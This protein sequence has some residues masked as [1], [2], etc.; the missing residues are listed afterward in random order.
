MPKIQKQSGTAFLMAIIAISLFGTNAVAL[1]VATDTMDPLVY[2]S[3]RYIGIGAILLLFL[4]NF[5]FLKK[6]GIIPKILIG[7]FLLM[8]YMVFFALG[9]S[10]SG[11]LKAA[12]MSL[13]TP[14]MVYI[15]SIILLHE[16]FIRRIVLGGL[17]AL[18]GSIILI[19]LPVVLG[20]SVSFG[21]IL[22]FLAYTA[23]AA[24]II[25]GKHMFRW[26]TTNELLSMRFAIGGI[27]LF[28]LVLFTSGP[29]VFLGGAPIAWI[30]LLYSTV[31]AGAIAHTLYFRALKNMRAEQTAPLFYIEPLVGTFLAAIVLGER[32]DLAVLVGAVIIVTGVSISH[33]HHNKLL[34]HYGHPKPRPKTSFFKN[35]RL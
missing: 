18:S 13:I 32:I 28:G 22:L 1:K 35:L 19:G 30:M 31:I 10:Q 33:P 29:D 3:A 23:L 26:V 27:V 15:F 14:V 11:A 5:R 17:V 21:D 2:A 20:Q 8:M 7:S 4:N 34:F 12:I 25:H 9:V 6:P 16:P 24:E